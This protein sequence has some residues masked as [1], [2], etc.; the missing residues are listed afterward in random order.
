MRVA[1][2]RK[3]WVIRNSKYWSIS[4]QSLEGVE[5]ILGMIQENAT[6]DSRLWTQDRGLRI[7]DS[8]SW[9]QDRGLRT[10][11]SGPWTQDRGL[12]NQD[13][14]DASASTIW[15]TDLRTS[16]S[17]SGG[18]SC[19]LGVFRFLWRAIAILRPLRSVCR[20]NWSAMVFRRESRRQWWSRSLLNALLQ[21]SKLCSVKKVIGRVE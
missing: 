21:L 19:D 4:K 12:W 9:T 18:N 1:S 5:V 13:S 7:V 20:L 16:E 8:G 17:T 11:D 3:L 14:V 2:L 15:P 10:V 6:Q